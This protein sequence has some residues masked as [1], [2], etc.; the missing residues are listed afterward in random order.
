MQACCLSLLQ[1]RQELSSLSPQITGM[2]AF[3]KICDVVTNKVVD[4][5]SLILE[6]VEVIFGDEPGVILVCDLQLGDEL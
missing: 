2:R 5:G 1:P 4:K 6:S 3:Q